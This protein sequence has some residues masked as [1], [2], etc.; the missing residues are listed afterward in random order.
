[1]TTRT[2]TPTV[3]STYPAT[4]RRVREVYIIVQ[5][6]IRAQDGRPISIRQLMRAA[7]MPFGTV[8][9]YL[10][11]LRDLYGYVTWEKDLGRTIRITERYD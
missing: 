9:Y 6:L 11:I 4:L 2:S 3:R 5:Q 1:M 10:L 7:N 8:R